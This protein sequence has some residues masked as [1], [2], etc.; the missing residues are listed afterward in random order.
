MPFGTNQAALACAS[1]GD[2]LQLAPSKSTPYPGVGTISQNVTITAAPGANARTVAI[3]ASITP[4]ELQNTIIA[5]NTTQYPVT[6]TA[7]PDCDGNLADLPGGHNIIGENTLC[8]ELIN[9]QHGD[10]VGTSQAPVDPQLAPLAFNCGNTETAPPL[11]AS[12]ATGRQGKHLAVKLSA[13]GSPTP[14]AHRV[15][16]PCRT[17]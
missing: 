12:P 9:G 1:G 8:G 2:V 10:Q 14:G 11:T 6:A 15:P 7:A 13:T 17:G 4:I 16:V 5:A 3:D